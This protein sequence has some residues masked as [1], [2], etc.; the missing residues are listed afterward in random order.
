[1]AGSMAD[2]HESVVT[3][4]VVADKGCCEDLPPRRLFCSSCATQ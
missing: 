2:M 4:V 1:M 3:L